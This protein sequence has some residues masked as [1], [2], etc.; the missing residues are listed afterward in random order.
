MAPFLQA[1][2][3]SLLAQSFA[4]FEVLLIDDGSTDGSGRICDD[5]AGKDPRVVVLHKE[6]GGV[7]SARNCGIDHARGEFIVFVDADDLVT[8]DYLEHLMESD[9]DMVVLGSQKFG[10]KND[11]EKPSRRNDF[12]IDSLAEHWNTPPVMNYLYCYFLGETFSDSN[13]PGAGYPFQRDAFLPRRPA[14][15]HALLLPCR[16]LH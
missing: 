7:C 14:F 12:S 4:D 5:L 13:H 2:V 10:A 1:C 9:A 15:Q 16:N 11:A 8:D 6:N 3:D